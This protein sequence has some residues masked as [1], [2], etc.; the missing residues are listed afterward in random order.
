MSR[1]THKSA[2]WP[3]SEPPLTIWGILDGG[4]VS[5]FYSQIP[6]W[7]SINKFIMYGCRRII[8]NHYY[9]TFLYGVKA[10]RSSSPPRERTW[11]RMAAEGA[12]RHHPRL[13]RKP[14]KLQN[15][16]PRSFAA[17]RRSGIQPFRD[18]IESLAGK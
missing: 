3:S 12:P 13:R 8:T 9:S 5:T 17:S 15:L 1:N 16:P 6:P 10:L 2:L 14:C 7:P 11:Q 18:Y 4:F